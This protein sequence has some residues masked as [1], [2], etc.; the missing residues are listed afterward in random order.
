MLLAFFVLIL[1]LLRCKSL[2]A[3]RWLLV[4]GLIQTLVMAQ[5]EWRFTLGAGL[6]S[7]GLVLQFYL[8]FFVLPRLWRR[9]SLAG[10]SQLR[11]R[12]G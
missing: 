10:M 9:H 6:L 8:W 1:V 7:L 5:I 4:L 3:L 11:L 12:R 2:A